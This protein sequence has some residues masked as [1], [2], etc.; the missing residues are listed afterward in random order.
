MSAHDSTT[1]IIRRRI[2]NW[3]TTICGIVT[4]LAPIAVLIWPQHAVIFTT[5][6]SAFTGAGLISAADAKPAPGI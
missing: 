1:M 2:R 3:K 6:I 4:I 5:V